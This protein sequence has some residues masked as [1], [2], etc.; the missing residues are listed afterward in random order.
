MEIAPGEAPP[1][2]GALTAGAS[3]VVGALPLA[4]GAAATAVGVDKGDAATGTV[5]GEATGEALGAATG[6]ATGSAA[7]GGVASIARQE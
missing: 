4:E 5:A 3:L 1:D 6:G 2:V 7:G